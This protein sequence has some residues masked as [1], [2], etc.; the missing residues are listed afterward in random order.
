MQSNDN[1]AADADAAS[2]DEVNKLSI[3][4]LKRWIDD[5]KI[6]MPAKRPKKKAGEFTSCRATVFLIA[7]CSTVNLFSRLHCHYHGLKPCPFSLGG[8]QYGQDRKE[9]KNY[10]DIY[11]LIEYLT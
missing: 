8:C 10:T 5:S 3:T 4:D 11:L 2:V 7:I 6:T 1:D 9:C